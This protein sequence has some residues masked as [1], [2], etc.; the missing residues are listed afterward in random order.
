MANKTPE[1]LI[2]DCNTGEQSVLSL[3]DE[4]IAE[5][6]SVATQSKARIAEEERQ[7]ADNALA[8]EAL[9]EKLGITEEEAKL[10]LS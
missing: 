3:S 7:A 5:L 10:L 8:R 1:K 2:V 9:L 6:K 4:E